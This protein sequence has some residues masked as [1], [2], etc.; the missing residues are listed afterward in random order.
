MAQRS[1]Y[2]YHHHS[3]ILCSVRIFHF[4]RMKSN[5]YVPLFHYWKL[6]GERPSSRVSF[7]ISPLQQP[8]SNQQHHPLQ[9][10]VT[11]SYLWGLSLTLDRRQVPLSH[12]PLSICINWSVILSLRSPN[13]ASRPLSIKLVL[14]QMIQF[15]SVSSHR[16]TQNLPGR[17]NGTSHGLLSQLR[18]RRP[19]FL[20]LP[21]CNTIW[22]ISRTK[23]AHL[24]RP[25]TQSHGD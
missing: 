19:A 11:N 3:P 20:A 14:G 10:I 5:C 1:H 23:S 4:K 25:V 21:W 16:L 17:D 18:A 24:R 6:E 9:F 22:L 13:S 7:S 12:H 8:T 2:H 15:P